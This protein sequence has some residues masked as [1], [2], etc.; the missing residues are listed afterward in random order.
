MRGQRAFQ[1]KMRAMMQNEMNKYGGNDHGTQSGVAASSDN[2][3]H[4]TDHSEVQAHS[5]NEHDSPHM[6][7]EPDNQF[8]NIE[9]DDEIFDFLMHS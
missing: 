6:T 5:S 9:N 3:D 1:N 4:A 8:W 7:H 2:T